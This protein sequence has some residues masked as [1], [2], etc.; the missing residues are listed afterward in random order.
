MST[1]ILIL[2]KIEVPFVVV[3][4]VCAKQ[5]RFSLAAVTWMAIVVFAENVAVLSFR[6]ARIPQNEPLGVR[7]GSTMEGGGRQQVVVAVEVVWMQ[8]ER[9]MCL[10]TF[11]RS[12]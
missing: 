6:H 1:F 11:A 7:K 9:I 5:Q 12:C 2:G 3:V 10:S 4:V 8:H